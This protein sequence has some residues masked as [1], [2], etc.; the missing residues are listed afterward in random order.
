MEDLTRAEA[1]D[2]L[3]VNFDTWPAAGSV[4][5]RAPGGWCWVRRPGTPLG[6]EHDPEGGFSRI[7]EK[8][9]LY[10]VVNAERQKQC[11]PTS[12]DWDGKEPLRVGHVCEQG[13]VVY[14]TQ[15]VACLALAGSL[16]G[17]LKVLRL[18]QVAAKRDKYDMLAGQMFG[19][20]LGDFSYSQITVSNMGRCLR[21]LEA[22]GKVTVHEQV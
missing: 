7:T 3:V 8:S 13:D 15:K 2:W 20:I 10:A 22:G 4:P 16:S 14:V 9:W 18:D 5:T 6:L 17:G 12:V 19:T 21:D 11:A 1:L